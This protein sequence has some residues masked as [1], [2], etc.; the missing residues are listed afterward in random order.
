MVLVAETLKQQEAHHNDLNTWLAAHGQT[1]RFYPAWDIL[2]HEKK[3]PHADIISERL[4]TLVALQ[5]PTDA[6][7]VIVAWLPPCCNRP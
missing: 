3:L 6:T 7:L 4:E 2:P 5:T 1:A